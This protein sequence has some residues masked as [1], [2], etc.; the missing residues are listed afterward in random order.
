MSGKQWCEDVAFRASQFLTVFSETTSFL[1]DRALL[2]GIAQALVVVLLVRLL[3]SCMCGEKEKANH[4]APRSPEAEELG[5]YMREHGFPSEPH[6]E[7]VFLP[8][9]ELGWNNAPDPLPFENDGCSGHFISLHRATYDKA[10]DRSGDYP[11]G[12]YFLKKSRVW[13][14]RMQLR[15]KDPPP[16]IADLFFG[17]ELDD[18]VHMSAGT[19]RTM[20]FFVRTLKG[21]VGKQVYHSPGDNPDLVSGLI[22]QPT[23][24]MPVWA[25]DQFIVTPEGEEPPRLNDPDIEFMGSKRVKRVNEFRK[26]L[27]ALDLQVGPV[28]TFFFWGISKWL[29][30][31]NWQVLIPLTSVPISFNKF[32]GNPPVRVVM[33]TLNKGR[34]TEKRHLKSFKKYYLNFAFW[35]SLNRPSAEKVK[36]LMREESSKQHGGGGQDLIRGLLPGK[37]QKGKKQW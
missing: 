26:E 19:K 15:F 18:Y 31:I 3:W 22:E 21:V 28:Y 1:Q 25:F 30:K 10:L 29:D 20:S 8:G 17:I 14:A 32:C 27:E 7:A 9:R 24:V 37:M 34:S 12:H 16:K 2:R 23:F 35:S 5:A 33:Y 11:Y 13:E 4:K 36:E 6:E